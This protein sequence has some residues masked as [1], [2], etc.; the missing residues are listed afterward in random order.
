MKRLLSLLVLLVLLL[1]ACDGGNNP[2]LPSIPETSSTEPTTTNPL[3]TAP[4]TPEVLPNG[5]SVKTDY[6]AYQPRVLTPKYTRLQKELISDLQASDAYGSI[7]P[8]IGTAQY[9][10]YYNG[11]VYQNGYSYGM[12]TK[13]GCIVADSVYSQVYRLSLPYWVLEKDIGASEDGYGMETRCA[14]AS[15]DGSVV[16]DCIYTRIIDGGDR[17]IAIHEY[18]PFRFDLLDE[19]LNVVLSSEELWESERLKNDWH[20]SYSEGRFVLAYDTGRVDEYSLEIVDYY[21]ADEKGTILAGPFTRVDPYQGGMALVT[22]EDWSHTYID[23]QGK[24][25][26]RSFDYAN[27]FSDSGVAVVDT[28]ETTEL[29]DRSGKALLSFPSDEYNISAEKEMVCVYCYTTSSDTLYNMDGTLLFDGS[30]HPELEWIY[31]TCF[32]ENTR[33]SDPYIVNI[34]TNER[35]DIPEGYS[36]WSSTWGARD[37]L[38]ILAYGE[39]GENGRRYRILNEEFEE[40]AV[41]VTDYFETYDVYCLVVKGQDG[42]VFFDEKGECVGKCPLARLD[43]VE[44]IEDGTFAVTDEFASYLYDEQFNL[45]FCYPLT[46]AMED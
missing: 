34:L 32:Y 17:I 30:E 6:S 7:Y 1:S 37:S 13:D 46:N 18:E 27:S 22:N 9:V 8:F 36:Y 39:Y 24:P 35:F 42:Y 33:A 4:S 44:A 21:I 2:I 38:I 3:P 40:V 20:M 16:T 5:V 19:N 12:V 45:L 28:G 14:L 41:D 43:K 29:I 15:L 25:M 23:L 31:G 11:Y 26:G 10:D